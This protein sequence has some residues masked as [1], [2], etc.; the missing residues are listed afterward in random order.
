MDQ[1]ELLIQAI[2]VRDHSS[3]KKIIKSVDLSLNHYEALIQCVGIGD[4]TS[5]RILLK[6]IPVVPLLTRE[7]CRQIAC[8]MGYKLIEEL[9]K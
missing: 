7:Y 8:I 5:T 1:N 4:I 3:I 2:M 6:H 9:F